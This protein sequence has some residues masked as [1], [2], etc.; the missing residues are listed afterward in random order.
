MKQTFTKVSALSASVL[1]TLSIAS[2]QTPVTVNNFSF[3]QDVTGN[4]TTTAPTGWTAF[5]DGQPNNFIGSQ[6]TTSAQ[7]LNS[8]PIATPGDGSQF[9]YINDNAGTA[10]DGIYQDVGTLLA[11][12]TYTLTVAIG[13]RADWS[14]GPNGQGTIS[15]LNGNDQTGTLLA[16]TTSDVV[17]QTGT[18]SD[19]TITYTTAGSVSGDL[20]VDLSV[21]GNPSAFSQGNFDN[22]RLEASAV[23]EPGTLALVGG[24]LALLPVLRRRSFGPKHLGR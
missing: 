24:G 8:P 7:Y 20:I 5:Y 15:L 17:S 9:L 23:P 21:V 1:L 14:P 2:A 19:F 4:A 16:S 11:D 12:T 3:E 6:L 10:T 22:V 18:F 13:S